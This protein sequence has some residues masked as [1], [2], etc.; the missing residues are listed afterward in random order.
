VSKIIHITIIFLAT[1]GSIPVGAQQKKHPASD[2]SYNL[3]LDRAI[4]WQH[5]AD[6]LHHLSVQWRK[7]AAGMID[8]LERGRLQAR[9][10]IIEDSLVVF[11]ERA[12][13]CFASLGSTAVPFILPDTVIDGIKVYRYNL[14]HEY[15]LRTKVPAVAD[16]SID[17]Q[18]YKTSVYTDENPFER[19]FSLPQGSFYRI[20]LAVYSKE[21]GTDHF[22][23]LFPVSTERIEDQE[24]TRFFVGK[25]SRLADA[26]RALRMVRPAGYPDAYIVAYYNGI[27]STPE[28]VRSLEKE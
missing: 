25:F 15:F 16:T 9:I 4:E 12:D 3:Q 11:R 10:V 28:K 7:E 24:L 26:E 23:G 13:S 2:S 8:P 20:Q 5:R 1:L 21:I 27:R 19:D 6:S 18:I 14:E 22:G 17:F